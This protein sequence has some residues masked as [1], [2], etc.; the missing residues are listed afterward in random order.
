MTTN[1]NGF[2]IFGAIEQK[3]LQTG[4]QGGQLGLPMSNETPTFDGVGRFQSFSGGTLSWRPETDAHMVYGLIFERWLQ[5]GRER[6]G[7]PVN[8][9][10]QTGDG[11][12]R[13][14]HFRALQLQGTPDASIFFRP[15]VGA[16]EVYGGI[17]HKWAELGWEGSPLGYPWH[18][19]T[20]TPDGSG[21]M[22][23]FT[24]GK[25]TWHTDHGATWG[26]I[27]PALTLRPISEGGIRF[28]AVNGAGY[29]P[30]AGVT[31]SYK[32]NASGQANQ[33]SGTA[34]ART[35]A[36]GTFTDARIPVTG[37]QDIS[38]AGVKGTDD[39]TQTS[40][41]AEIEH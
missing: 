4:A 9:E 17:R 8:D 36:S 40:T 10:S 30:N 31:L 13:Y 34:Q 19:E 14:N 25:I 27:T 29:T 35:A 41:N 3:W 1:L 28:I 23:H 6:F 20:A 32:M 24:G 5:L 11:R 39:V 26:P 2:T 15:G 22:Q 16:H 38:Y 7:Y 18:E 12:G 21:R 33:I 37:N